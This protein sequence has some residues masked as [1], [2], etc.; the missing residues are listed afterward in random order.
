M[1]FALLPGPN[2]SIRRLLLNSRAVVMKAGPRGAEIKR[3]RFAEEKGTSRDRKV[4][5]PRR[6]SPGCSRNLYNHGIES[7]KSR[8]K[9]T[10]QSRERCCYCE[11]LSVA[12][13][14]ASCLWRARSRVHARF[15]FPRPLSP[16][17]QI[18]VRF[19]WSP[20][21]QGCTSFGFS[22]KAFVIHISSDRLSARFRTGCRV[23]SRGAEKRA[24]LGAKK[25]GCGNWRCGN[26]I[27]Q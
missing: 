18:S 11:R 13:Q 17:G 2:E 15:L 9:E 26:S 25:S 5:R 3:G 14:S 23:D 1:F 12:R 8:R 16:P 19:S 7:G 24:L 4:C 27:G 6:T 21:C 22:T 10:R 20:R